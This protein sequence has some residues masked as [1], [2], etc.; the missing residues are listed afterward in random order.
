MYLP[1]QVLQQFGHTQGIP[2][3]PGKS[4]DFLTD[5]VAIY[6]VFGQLLD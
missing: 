1:E 5:F 4:A 2:R 3:H 6:P